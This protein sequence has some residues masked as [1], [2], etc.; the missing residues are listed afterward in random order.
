MTPDDH[1]LTLR[2]P[3]EDLAIRCPRLGHQVRFAYCR[4]EN[5][6]LPCSKALVCWQPHFLVAEYLSQELNTDQWQKAFAEPPKQKIVHLFDLIRKAQ[7][8]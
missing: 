3:N 4:S 2:P 1:G 5:L 6:G 7:E 8:E